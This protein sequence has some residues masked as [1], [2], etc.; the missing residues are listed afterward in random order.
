MTGIFTPAYSVS[1]RTGSDGHADYLFIVKANQPTLHAQL[2]GLPWHK[3]PVMDR[4]RDHAHGRVELR[5][6]KVASVQGLDF[7]M[8]PK[9]CRS[10]AV[11]VT[12]AAAGGAPLPC[13]P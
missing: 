12:Q 2:I 10:P 4:S 6:L 5:T 8:P 9:P 1:K 11:C 13:T 3:I 7:P